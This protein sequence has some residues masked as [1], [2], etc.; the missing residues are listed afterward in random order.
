MNSISASQAFID[1]EIVGPTLVAWDE[2]GV[3]IEVRSIPLSEVDVDAILS[4]GFID[5]QVNGIDE[6]NVATATSQDWVK[7][8]R[9]LLGTGVTSW[10]PTL[11]SNPLAEITTSLKLI[12][13]QIDEQSVEK[14][15]MVSEIIGVHLEGPFLGS[16][17]GAHD[18]RHVIDVDIEWIREL[19]KSVKL[20]TMGAEQSQAVIATKILREH[21]A[22]VSIGH[23]RA[24]HEQIQS[25]KNAG[26]SI[27]THLFNAMSGVHHREEGVAL[28]VLTDSDLFASI[29]VDLEHVSPQ[30]V[31]LAFLAKP[32]KMIL[33]TD[34]VA[35][36]S[37]TAPRLRDGTLA[38][39]VL[40]MDQAI[41]NAVTHCSVPL[42]QALAAATVNPATAMNLQ[43]RGE[44]AIGKKADF[45][46]LSS[47]LTIEQ[48]ICR[49]R[50]IANF[51]D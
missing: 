28:S 7:L 12:A 48:M 25:M 41:R 22:T 14:N 40:K 31:Q 46:V 23:S 16:A 11:I 24:T 13:R 30:A 49:G 6:I 43:D 50:S 34:S 2:A 15:Q 36:T 20:V 38:G 5:I 18:R 4:P 33:I 39:S 37:V 3:V 26:A 21:G 51:N 1:G 45:V 47:S 29:I 8:S 44:I 17:T 9:L 32:D 10:C 42:H 35:S 19:P 27:V